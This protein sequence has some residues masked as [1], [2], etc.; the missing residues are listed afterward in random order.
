MS[1]FSSTRLEPAA[2]SGAGWPARTTFSALEQVADTEHVVQF[3]ETDPFLVACVSRFV[4]GPLRRGSGAVVIATS[5]HLAELEK[6][7]DLEELSVEV[8]GRRGQYVGLDAEEILD[9]VLVDGLPDA[10]RFRRIVGKHVAVLASRWARVA[11]FDQMAGVLWQQGRPEAA[12]MLHEQWRGLA[13]TH[14]FA[15][16]SAYPVAEI[17]DDRA[18]AAL[19]RMCSA[20]GRVLPPQRSGRMERDRSLRRW[21]SAPVT[22]ERPGRAY[23]PRRLEGGAMAETV[24]GTMVD[25]GLAASSSA[26][27]GK[28]KV[29]IV[30]DNPAV[31]ETLS[32][33]LTIL[34]N[35]V[36]SAVDGC[37]ALDVGSDFHPDVIFMDIGMPN[38]NGYDAARR[39]RQ[40]PWGEDVTLVAL[41]GWGQ[42]EHRRRTGEAGFDEHLVKPVGVSQLRRLLEEPVAHD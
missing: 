26:S 11:A 25:G 23:P 28:R 16:L 29:L 17:A 39:I 8:A 42:P 27:P 31:V 2:P 12:Q 32:I 24:A 37:D 30:D 14:R 20:Y 40:L 13:R 15:L 6:S 9:A 4:R 1:P 36:R 34:G 38:M 22:S 33:A 7:L 19:V 21:W 41:T 18:R 10:R 3:Y 35:E 5:E